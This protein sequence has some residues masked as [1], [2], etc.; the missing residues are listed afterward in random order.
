MV[1]QLVFTSSADGDLN[2][3]KIWYDNISPILT[4]DLFS[5][6]SEEFKIIK[7]SPQIY[8]TRYRE[9]RIAFL[10]RFEYG[11]HFIVEGKRIIILR[12]LH[13]KQYFN[14]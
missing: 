13:N 1:Y 10:K 4:D 11:V 5:E 14:E 9:I 6:L 2:K 7:K 12:I 8:Q 3:I